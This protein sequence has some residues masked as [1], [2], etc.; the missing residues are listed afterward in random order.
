MDF[1]YL[2]GIAVFLGLCV[3]LTA[4]CDALRNRKTGGR[5]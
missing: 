2:V 5:P 1:M 3:T 4:A